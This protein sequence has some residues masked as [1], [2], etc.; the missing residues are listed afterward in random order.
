MSQVQDDPSL[1]TD[2]DFL[3]RLEAEAEQEDTRDSLAQPLFML[4]RDI[5]GLRGVFTWWR[6]Q[7][8]SFV[9]LTYGDTIS[10]ALHDSIEWLYS[11]SQ[12]LY[13]LQTFRTSMFPES[14]VAPP[15][16]SQQDREATRI[17]VI[18]AVHIIL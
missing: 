7:V 8:I 12:V 13:Y 5:F 3:D 1:F 9:N 15:P 6:G 2:E 14:Y 10:R 17:E 4:L 18:A 16:R 11:E